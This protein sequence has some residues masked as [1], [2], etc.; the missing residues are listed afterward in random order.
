MKQQDHQSEASTSGSSHQVK[1][2]LFSSFFS[3]IRKA[4]RTGPESQKNQQFDQS[5]HADFPENKT[6]GSLLKSPAQVMQE[7]C[8]SEF[9]L[10]PSTKI[11]P[12]L[13]NHRANQN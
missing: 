8:V 5:V 9:R 11:P 6:D 13:P 3:L 1:H 7:K 2:P 4:S 10:D 12:F